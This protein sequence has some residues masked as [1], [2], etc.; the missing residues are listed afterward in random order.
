MA[1][2]RS[3]GGFRLPPGQILLTGLI[4]GAG[5]GGLSGIL[6]GGMVGDGGS[7]DIGG[8]YVLVGFIG[9]LTGSLIGLAS[10][11]LAIAA[12]AVYRA[13]GGRSRQRLIVVSA[14]AASVTTVG[15][16]G[17]SSPTVSRCSSLR[18]SSLTCWRRRLVRYRCRRRGK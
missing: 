18:R 13:F 6:T 16:R 4:V 5:A 15:A 10:A 14:S 1:V 7:G 2:R 17:G 3:R 8:A 11:A 12:T 9:L